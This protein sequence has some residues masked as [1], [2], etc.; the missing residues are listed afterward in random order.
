MPTGMTRL[1]VE[2]I[3]G[4]L[5]RVLEDAVESIDLR[6]VRFVDP[7]ALL[8]LDLLVL[9]ANA[10]QSGPRIDWPEAPAVRRWMHA[11]GFFAEVGEETTPPAAREVRSA[12]QPITAISDETAIGRIVDGRPEL[13]RWTDGALEVITTGAGLP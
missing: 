3:D 13:C 10:R 5:E 7:Y 12:L 11:M 6:G 9:E 1:T 8:L 2:T 4:V